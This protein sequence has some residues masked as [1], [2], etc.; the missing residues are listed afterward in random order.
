MYSLASSLTLELCWCVKYP[1]N[2]KPHMKI[3]LHYSAFLSEKCQTFKNK[4]KTK[5]K[6]E[7]KPMIMYRWYGNMFLRV[8]FIS[9][10]SCRQ[11]CQKL[12]AYYVCLSISE[13]LHIDL[14][15]RESSLYLVEFVFVGTK[16][17]IL[18]KIRSTIISHQAFQ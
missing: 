16:F 14:F 11:T 3:N 7:K 9:R 4:S 17:K 5:M 13:C 15:S 1:D 6:W 12:L 2:Y 10:C 18:F 8:D